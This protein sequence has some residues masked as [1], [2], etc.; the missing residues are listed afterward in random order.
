MLLHWQKQ[1]SIIEVSVMN[2][3]IRIIKKTLYYLG[4]NPKIILRNR[5]KLKQPSCSL[6][7]W[8]K[9]KTT[10]HQDLNQLA[11]KPSRKHWWQMMEI[12][13]TLFCFR[14]RS[15]SPRAYSHLKILPKTQ[16]EL[17]STAPPYFFA[18]RHLKFW[19]FLPSAWSFASHKSHLRR[20]GR[21]WYP[22]CNWN[23]AGVKILKN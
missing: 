3:H 18:T 22:E 16:E 2:N 19:C 12:S 20:G 5:D 4:S 9:G 6:L 7:T 23:Y 8:G 1:H 15:W 11:I 17:L 10:K 21:T 14:P 13:S